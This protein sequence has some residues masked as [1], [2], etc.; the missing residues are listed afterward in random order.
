VNFSINRLVSAIRRQT[1]LKSALP[2]NLASKI[3][4]DIF[5]VLT[6]AISFRRVRKIAKS[7]Y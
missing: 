3:D 4:T 1:G 2:F 7:D 6:V 5:E